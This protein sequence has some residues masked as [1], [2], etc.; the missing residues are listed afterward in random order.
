MSEHK[1]DLTWTLES[2]AFTYKE[3][4]REHE[5]RFAGG[6]TMRAS[7]AVEYL[8]KADH[9][10][11]EEMLVAALSSCHMLTFL[12]VAAK[13]GFIV[14]RYEDKAVGHLE[15]NAKGKLAVTRTELHPKVTFRD[16]T[17]DDEQLARMHDTS[18][19]ECFIANSVLTE[20]TVVSA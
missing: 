16:K 6:L 18:H 4:N 19:H 1:I 3:Y 17:P 2:N 11:P 14:E 13:R 15:K 5:I 20:V 9:P 7:S 8:G 10:N 12:A